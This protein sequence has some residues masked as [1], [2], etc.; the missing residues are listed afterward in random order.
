MEHKCVVYVLKCHNLR[1]TRL[2]VFKSLEPGPDPASHLPVEHSASREAEDLIEGSGMPGTAEWNDL[3]DSTAQLGLADLMMIRDALWSEYEPTIDGNGLEPVVELD[4]QILAMCPVG[5]PDRAKAYEQLAT[6]IWMRS[7]QVVDR[8]PGITKADGAPCEHLSLF[9]VAHDA[10]WAEYQEIEDI[11]ILEQVIDLGEQVLSLCASAEGHRDAARLSLATSLGIHLQESDRIGA[12]QPNVSRV[13]ELM[14]AGSLPALAASLWI[15]YKE[16][17]NPELL[18]QVIAIEVAILDSLS[19]ED[20]Q[21]VLA[22]ENLAISLNSHYSQSNNVSVLEQV[23]QR[24]NEAYVLCPADHERH[25][26]ICEGRATALYN[27]YQQKGSVSLFNE[28][29]ELF[30]EAL[31]LRPHGHPDRATSCANL[32]VSLS[33]R[34]DQTGDVSLLNE[35]IELFRQ[36]LKLHP[37]GHPD[38]AKSCANLAV[39]LSTR[40]DQTGDVSL[41]NEATELQ[42]EVLKS[43]PHGHPY[44]AKSC[45]NLAVSLKTRYNQTGDVSLLNEATKLERE[46]LKLR[47][48][49]HPDRAK[50]CTNLAVSLLTRYNQTG[51]VSLLNEATE[52]FREALKLRP[53]G[54]PDR[55]TSCANL[56]VSLKTRYD[57]TGDVS[58]LN[59]A[60]EHEHEALELRPHGHPDRATSCTNLAASLLTRYNQTGDVSLPNEATELFREALKLRPH[61]H[62]D[63]AKLSANLAVSLKT[64]YDQTGDVSLLNEATELFLQALKLHPRGHPDRAKLCA[65]LAVSLKTR[66]DQTGDVSLLN[67]ATELFREALKLRPHGHPDRATSCADL[68]ASLLTRYIQT[69]DVSLLNEVTELFREALKLRPYG[70]PDCATLSANLAASLLTRYNQT[71]DVSLLN[72]ATEL[73]REALKLRPHGHPNRAT[74]CANLAVSLSTRYD[75]TGDVSLLNEATELEREAL[76]LY[77]HG[78]PDRATSCTNLAVSL[79]TR[80]DQT[81]DVSLLNEATKLCSEA[82]HSFPPSQVW[83]SLGLQCQLYLSHV[84]TLDHA[85]SSALASLHLCSDAEADDIGPYMSFILASL[86]KFW[87]LY[88]YWT[89]D[90]PSSLV[91]AYVSVVNK[92][93]LMAAFVLDTSSRLLAL[94][95]FNRLGSQACV[96]AINTGHLPQAIEL[97]DHA[98]GVIW[99]QA[100]HQRDPQLA[101]VPPKL[102][103][104]LEALLRAIAVP[105]TSVPTDRTLSPQ[106]LRHEQNSQI[107]NLLREIRALPGLDCFMRGNKFELLRQVANHPVVTL[108]AF[109]GQVYAIIIKNSSDQPSVLDLQPQFLRETRGAKGQRELSGDDLVEAR[110]ESAEERRAWGDF[111]RLMRPAGHHRS[112]SSQLQLLW[113]FIVKPVLSHLGLEV[114]HLTYANP[115]ELIILSENGGRSTSTAPLVPNWSLCIAS[116]PRS[117]HLCGPQPRVLIRLRGCLVYSNARLF[118]S[119]ATQ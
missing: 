103:S 107:Q 50:S 88:A 19:G 77:P 2:S 28:A 49:G 69:G 114:S 83:R 10:L 15:Q 20:P 45:A 3:A 32:A 84:P 75:Q 14:Y 80:Y 111:E 66:Y 106:D 61:G 1:L 110:I 79:L 99:A 7:L 72:E 109:H 29:T 119:R 71:G 78:H 34:Y 82:S 39:S 35:A 105:V 64:R 43:R 48:H 95:S 101:D 89:P 90:T 26:Y 6:S 33:T 63:R 117:R 85:L 22:C 104:D 113:R 9:K 97:L 108:V 65:N 59:E 40:Y 55:A 115:S 86:N 5:H 74:S 37:R 24:Y 93:P 56:A 13:M 62:P 12:T 30:R 27:L 118:A 73:F 68:A 38:R 25:V 87:S 18:D 100:L 53:H 11:G 58:L 31:K 91:Y 8:T 67:E 44:R 4:Q 96:A 70:H 51:D 94:R 52:L 92:L 16:N 42:H 60:T 46:A 21:R 54:H 36:A 81:G 98:H 23:V 102:A 47:P 41:L 112:L 57:Q 76:K 17:S 116:P